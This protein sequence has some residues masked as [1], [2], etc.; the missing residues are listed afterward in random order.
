M[1]VCVCVLLS[2]SAVLK[3]LDLPDLGNSSVR[4]PQTFHFLQV[5]NLPLID[6]D[7]NASSLRFRRACFALR[8]GLGG[9]GLGA[10]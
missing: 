7:M 8:V 2:P 10:R 1:C 9:F 5:C 4:L 6:R 3:A